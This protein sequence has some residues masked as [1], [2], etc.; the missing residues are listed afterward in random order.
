MEEVIENDNSSTVEEVEG[1]DSTNSDDTSS[2]HTDDESQGE[3]EYTER[4]KQLY[5]R[6]KKAEGF[7]LV[8]GK[9]VKPTK[10]APKK[11]TK[12]DS[13]EDITIARLEA[14]G[15]LNAD[16][17]AYVLKFA[18]VEGVHYLEALEDDFVKEKLERNKKAR[19]SA[20]ANPR[21]NNRAPGEQNEVAAAVKR[22]E[23]DGTLPDN[24]ALIAKVMK[25]I[26]S[27]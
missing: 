24:P 12:K 25:A 20:S 5:A 6:L 14:R 7:E 26:K 13:S 22:Y 19:L 15:I 17:Q 18:K 27:Q 8:D 1:T 16:D 11:E 2:E 9:W 21:G 10:P 4:E 23:K 3:E